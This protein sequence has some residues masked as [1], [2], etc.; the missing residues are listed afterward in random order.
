ML[1]CVSCE[2]NNGENEGASPTRL[3]GDRDTKWATDAEIKEL[4]GKLDLTFTDKIIFSDSA[5]EV[6]NVV[7]TDLNGYTCPTS[8][9]PAKIKDFETCLD[10]SYRAPTYLKWVN[11]DV[12]YGVFASEDIVADKF[13]TTY[14]GKLFSDSDASEGTT[15]TWSYP[16]SGTIKGK[17][18]A[19][20]GKDCGNIGRFFND[21]RSDSGN[22]LLSVMIYSEKEKNYNIVY[23]AS[24]NVMKDQELC[25]SYGA[26]YWATRT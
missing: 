21:A 9:T 3:I 6:S 2:C 4:F 15:W 13:V 26:A 7:R 5:K 16:I 23:Y 14:T 12:G 11:D 17:K 18:Y 1:A 25:V 19:L 22:N 8:L 10:S 24:K 20:S